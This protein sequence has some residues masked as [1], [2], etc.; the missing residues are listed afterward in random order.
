MAPAITIHV[1]KLLQPVLFICKKLMAKLNNCKIH[2]FTCLKLERNWHKKLIEQYYYRPIF[3]YW[4]LLMVKSKWKTGR[5]PRTARSSSNHFMRFWHSN[6]I[7]LC[8]YCQLCPRFYLIILIFA[9]QTTS[10]WSSTWEYLTKSRIYTNFQIIQLNFMV[11]SRIT[12]RMI[13]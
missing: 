12:C 3:A 4:S 10:C 13:Y 9:R 1:L 8:Q 6:V 5:R 2:N 11:T 7:K